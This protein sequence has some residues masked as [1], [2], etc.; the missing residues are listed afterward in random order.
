MS[1]TKLYRDG[2]FVA[3]DAVYVA[4]DAPLPANAR[5]VVSKARY[6]SL[7]V[8]ERPRALLLETADTLDGLETA[9]ERLD[10]IVLR[11]AR[12]ADGRPYSLAGRLRARFGFAGE[13]RAIGDVLHDQIFL[14]ERQGFDSFGVTHPGTIRALAEN[15][16]VKVPTRAAFTHGAA[17]AAAE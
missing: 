11:F 3:D 12:Y 17:A 15:R 1:E 7:P 4:N 16:I 5:A 6:L 14:L 9:V 10:L 13:L 8:A 2:T